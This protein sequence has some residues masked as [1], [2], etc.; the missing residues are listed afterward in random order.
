[1]SDR[2][3]IDYI[4]NG[5]AH[6]DVATKFM[7]SGM[8]PGYMRP[9]QGDDG[10]YYITINAGTKKEKTLRTNAV[11]TLRYDEW[12]LI[13][14]SVLRIGKASLKLWGDLM[15]AGLRFNVPNGMGVMVIQHQTMTDVTRATVSID[16]L[17]RGDRDRP[18]FATEYLPLPIIHKDGGF[19][20][21]EI[22]TGRRMG[23]PIDTMTI[24]M[25]TE[26]CTEEVERFLAGTNAVYTYGGG[27]IY[28]YLNHPS[29]LTY[30]MTNPTSGGWTPRIFLQEV[31]AMKKLG[32]DAFQRGPWKFYV[33]SDWDEVLDDDYSNE[34][35]GKTLRQRV[36]DIDGVAAPE[37]ADYL[38]NTSGYKAVMVQMKKQTVEGVQGM[39]LTTVRWT[40]QGGYDT[41]YKVACIM[42]PRLRKDANSNTGIIEGSA[43]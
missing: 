23:T 36:A 28:G 15:G 43:A 34:Y 33:S 38:T 9:F 42:V 20:L 1:M 14:E 3:T 41:A 11:A 19:T 37:T 13:D 12:K 30:T 29:R 32:Y 39:G 18:T 6:G 4:H 40:E 7:E 26:R 5:D 22:M 27:S 31:L 25:A 10:N 8:D 16:G 35:G 24:E 21:R 17:R 2:A